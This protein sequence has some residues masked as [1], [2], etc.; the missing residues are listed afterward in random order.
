MTVQSFGE[1]LRHRAEADPERRAFTFL[2]GAGVQHSITYAELDRLARCIAAQLQNEGALG[3][4]VLVA[5]DPGLD[6]V[7]GLFGCFYAGAVAVPVQPFRIKRSFH[8]FGAIAD[9]SRA[10]FVI[11]R[12]SLLA[13]T[14]DVPSDGLRPGSLK[15]IAIDALEQGLEDVW[16]DPDARA[17]SL[18]LLQYTS[19]STGDPK[20]VM[21]SHGNLIA[22]SRLIRDCFDV[23][24]EDCAVVWLP[25]YHD[26]GLIGGILQPIFTGSLGILFDPVSF[27]K[28][29][30]TWLKLIS[31]FKATC[32]GGPNFAY[33]LCASKAAAVPVGSLDL[34][35]WRVAC[36]GA[37][38][39]HVE[40]LERFAKSFAVHGFAADA[41]RPCYGLAE[42]TLIA[43]GMRARGLPRKKSVL[44]SALEEGRIV[45]APEHAAGAQNIVGCGQQIGEEHEIR[46][47]DPNR[48]VAVSDGELGEVWLRGPSVAQ[49]YFN[50]PAE[51]E[52]T[53]RA[54]LRGEGGTPFLRTGDL[55]FIEGGELFLTGRIKDLIIIAGRNHHPE[56]IEWTVQKCGSIARFGATAAFSIDRGGEE[57]LVILQEIDRREDNLARTYDRIQRAVAD[58]HG[59]RAHAIE[60]TRP[61]ALPRTTSNKIRRAACR[62]AFLNGE[63]AVPP[64]QSSA[65]LKDAH[66]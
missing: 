39:I 46:I 21:V 15:W 23:T 58:A 40:T 27:L 26:M 61:H 56:D 31:E 4:R 63:F 62:A 2:S 48:F 19:G 34:S 8:R 9:D 16:Q 20:G 6:Y 12:R 45:D 36:L 14:R 59:I 60:F 47:V 3:E 7:A 29:P 33:E 5:C 52:T 51:S 64:L 32:S 37:E 18:A 35:S 55:G 13:S 42:A 54:V 44:R 17:D 53:F 25:P 38:P 28:H 1:I 30:L 49:G 22:N 50:R 10:K 43:S 57:R 41:Y 65:T 24:A 66:A 11:A